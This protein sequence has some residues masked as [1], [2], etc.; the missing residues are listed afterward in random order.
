MKYIT[1]RVLLC[2][3][4]LDH[5]AIP[6]LYNA[7]KTTTFTFAITLAITIATTTTLSTITFYISKASYNIIA[8]FVNKLE[9]R[10]IIVLI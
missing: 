9:K 10:P 3:T 5:L 7:N 6:T 1:I 2:V 4:H 8:I